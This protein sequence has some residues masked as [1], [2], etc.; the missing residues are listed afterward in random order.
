MVPDLIFFYL[1][2]IGSKVKVVDGGNAAEGIVTSLSLFSIIVQREDGQDIYYPNN[3]AVQ[4]SIVHL[5]EDG[6]ANKSI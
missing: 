1:F 3:L 4:K 5:K 6:T 2:K